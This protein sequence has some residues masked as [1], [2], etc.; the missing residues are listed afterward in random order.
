MNTYK[1]LLKSADALESQAASKRAQ[2]TE[3]FKAARKKNIKNWLGYCFESSCGLTEDFKEFA[4][5]FKK[6]IKKIMAGYTL[7][8]FNRGHFYISAFFKNDL[9][10]KYIYIYRVQMFGISLIRGIEIY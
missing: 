1:E 3:I 7:I 4:A 9:N 2:A 6:Y 5:Q 10:G 8:A